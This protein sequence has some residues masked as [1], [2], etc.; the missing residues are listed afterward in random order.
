MFFKSLPLKSVGSFLLWRDS[1]HLWSPLLHK[2]WALSRIVVI[3][4]L[5]ELERFIMKKLSTKQNAMVQLA[6][7][8]VG[9]GIRAVLVKKGSVKSFWWGVPHKVGTF[10][11]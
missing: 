9:L 6:S 2:R 10:Q 11:K 3:Q 1:L 5:F 4:N 8:T 7:F